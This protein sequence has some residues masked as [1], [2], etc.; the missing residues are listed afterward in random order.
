VPH[1][2]GAQVS[3]FKKQRAKKKV[4]VVVTTAPDETF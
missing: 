3:V 2:A 1:R 4:K